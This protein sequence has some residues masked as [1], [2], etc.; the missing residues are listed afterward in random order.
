MLSTHR[1]RHA[2]LTALAVVVLSA[3]PAAAATI[4]PR[5][6]GVRL[7]FD[8][9]W[10]M[11]A[12]PH[13]SISPEALHEMQV[14]MKNLMV[15]QEAF[16]S[17]YG[18]YA[19]SIQVM[20]E[21]RYKPEAGVTVRITWA[22]DNA[23]AVE[24][25]DVLSPGATCIV[26]VN[27]IPRSAWPTTALEKKTGPEGHIVCDGDGKPSH[28]AWQL[29][30]PAFMTVQ[31]QALVLPQERARGATGTYPA[32]ASKIDGNAFD[33]A[34]HF[35]F[36]WADTASWAAKAVYDSIPGK[37]CVVWAGAHP[38]TGTRSRM[39]ARTEAQH[40]FPS[41]GEVACDDF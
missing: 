25:S 29:D 7:A 30:V 39:Y 1:P 15:A 18:K 23:Y 37:S 26:H 31:L 13:D 19:P 21:A 14:S 3:I 27:W 6:A 36:L 10:R 11:D 2:V 35:T 12:I 34:L 5:P 32:D 28:T 8:S 17:D 22:N 16:Y 38:W 20:G 33:P 41:R 24:A 9:P 40:R 4:V